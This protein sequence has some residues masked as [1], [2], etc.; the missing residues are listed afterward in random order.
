M[1]EVEVAGGVEAAAGA[2]LTRQEPNQRQAAPLPEAK[3]LNQLPLGVLEG[4]RDGIDRGD[5][6]DAPRRKRLSSKVLRMVVQIKSIWKKYRRKKSENRTHKRNRNAGSDHS[7]RCTLQP[8]V[9]LPQRQVTLCAM[10]LLA[11]PNLF[12]QRGQQIERDVRRLKVGRIG[13]GHVVR[14]RS[15]R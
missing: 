2:H 6:Q 15:K 1:R 13:V 4:K 14:E 7:E 8:T 12:L 3:G 11:V 5:G 9:K 10:A